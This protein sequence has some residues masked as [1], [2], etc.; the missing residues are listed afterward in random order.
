MVW[1]TEKVA[2]D[3]LQV[4][5]GAGFVGFERIGKKDVDRIV[6]NAVEKGGV[7]GMQWCQRFLG[8][9]QPASKK[10]S[11]CLRGGAGELQGLG[12]QCPWQ[13]EQLGILPYTW[14]TAG[15]E[16]HGQDCYMRHIF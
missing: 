6:M 14:G 7:G 3:C 16:C 9:K 10:V 11:E 8:G 1:E 5:L 2:S 12:R 4:V 13:A 15:T